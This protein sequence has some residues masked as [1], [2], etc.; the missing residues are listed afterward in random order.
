MQLKVE[1]VKLVTKVEDPSARRAIPV[2][3]VE[4]NFPKVEQGRVPGPTAKA[5][6][7]FTSQVHPS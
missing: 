1:E 7:T 4:R 3:H 2:L 6:L 5:T